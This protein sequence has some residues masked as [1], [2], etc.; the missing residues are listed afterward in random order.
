MIPTI[1]IEDQIDIIPLLEKYVHRCHEL[2]LIA[3]SNTADGG[4]QLIKEKKPALIL[5]DI[6]LKGE[7]S[8]IDILEWM[9]E[10]GIQGSIIFITAYPEYAPT[11]INNLSF[12]RKQRFISFLQKPLEEAML[13]ESIQRLLASQY[14]CFNQKEKDCTVTKMICFEDILYCEGDGAYTHLFLADEK[15]IL[16]SE[17]LKLIQQRLPETY[18]YRTGKSHII[19][20]MKVVNVIVSK[21]IAVLKINQNEIEINLG[22]AEAEHLK[23]ELESK[24][25]R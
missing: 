19:A 21:G 20:L 8:G 11:I 15:R 16:V 1:I 12:N 17:N 18:F 10:E 14:T 9:N 4:I 22:K 3:T 5:L 7:K 25:F 6:Q 13:K 24:Q 23:K 2:R